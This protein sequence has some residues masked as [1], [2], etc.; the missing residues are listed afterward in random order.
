MHEGKIAIRLQVTRPMDFA[1]RLPGIWGTKCIT[2]RFHYTFFSASWYILWQ[3]CLNVCPL[4]ITS[5]LDQE[6]AIN[7]RS[8]RPAPTLVENIISCHHINVVNIIF[9]PLMSGLL[10]RFITMTSHTDTIPRC[11]KQLFCQGVPRQYHI[12]CSRFNIMHLTNK[13]LTDSRQFHTICTGEYWRVL[14]RWWNSNQVDGI[15]TH[16]LSKFNLTV[17]FRWHS[18]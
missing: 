7:H 10:G 18:C 1:A 16:Q 5:I 13:D 6:L 12:I 9:H 15:N 2:H 14:S 8:R 3:L 4:F 11:L 17:W